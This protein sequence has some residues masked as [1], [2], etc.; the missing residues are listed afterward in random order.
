MGEG[1]GCDLD[2]WLAGLG[3]GEAA[4]SWKIEK[5]KKRSFQKKLNLT[6]TTSIFGPC[7]GEL[8]NL[9]VQR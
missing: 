6:V 8:R 3:S 1:D 2:G 4:W 5:K 7:Y 9:L